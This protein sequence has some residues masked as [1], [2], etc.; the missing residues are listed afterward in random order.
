MKF[1]SALVA[2]AAATSA[3][4]AALT[5][6]GIHDC[7]GQPYYPDSYTCYGD[8]LCPILNGVIYQP[9]GRACFDPANYGCQ[10]G[11][12]VPVSTCNGQVYDKNSYVCVSNHLCPKTHPN[13]CGEACYSLS[14]YT[15]KKGQLVQV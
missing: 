3:S 13:L 7:A 5:S 1:T 4:A 2:L 8:L 9:C 15:C 10:Y 6:R 14:Q 12:L 11:Q